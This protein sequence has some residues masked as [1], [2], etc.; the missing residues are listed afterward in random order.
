VATESGA[1]CTS[2]ACS[3]VQNAAFPG[4][5]CSRKAG[6]SS[7]QRGPG[8]PASSAGTAGSWNRRGGLKCT[9]YRAW[10]ASYLEPQGIGPPEISG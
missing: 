3:S 9:N 1:G 6:G 4:R 7:D 8:A 2:G 10:M 5:A